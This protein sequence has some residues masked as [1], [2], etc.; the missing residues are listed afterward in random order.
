MQ[1]RKRLAINV[2][3]VS[4]EAEAHAGAQGEEVDDCQSPGL[5]LHFCPGMCTEAYTKD[6]GCEQERY[7][8]QLRV[9]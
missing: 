2:Q 7:C 8:Q 5:C 6:I 9:C 3:K 4:R 1:P